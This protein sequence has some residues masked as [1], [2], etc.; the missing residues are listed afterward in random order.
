LVLHDEDDTVGLVLADDV[1]R[2]AADG[3]LGSIKLQLDPERL[4][5]PIRVQRKPGSKV[6]RFVRPD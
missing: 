6:Q 2:V 3:V 5:Q 1:K 4:S